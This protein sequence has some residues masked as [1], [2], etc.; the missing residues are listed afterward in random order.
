MN[1]LYLKKRLGVSR[2]LS[3]SAV[4]CWWV[5][6]MSGTILAVDWLQNLPAEDGGLQQRGG[7]GGE[8]VECV[9]DGHHVCARCSSS[10][11]CFPR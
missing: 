4:G 6:T 1:F 11:P 2:L 8:C 9:A 10:R 7:A 5:F 3:A